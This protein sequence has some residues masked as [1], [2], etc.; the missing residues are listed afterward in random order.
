M[1]IQDRLIRDRY[2]EININVPNW[3]E[4]KANSLCG[5]EVIYKINKHNI[6]QKVFNIYFTKAT[7]KYKETYN[8]LLDD[9]LSFDLHKTKSWTY[10]T[11]LLYRRFLY[12]HIN[13]NLYN[14]NYQYYSIP[15]YNSTLFQMRKAIM[16]Q[17]V[18]TK[19]IPPIRD[20]NKPYTNG[21]YPLVKPLPLK[22][23]RKRADMLWGVLSFD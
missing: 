6:K 13:S 17:L 11:S 15:L 21:F 3:D 7:C 8:S 1:S 20:F 9:Y 16:K 19:Q 18:V 22:E 10:I 12:F 2:S 14:N 4:L 5:R 23:T